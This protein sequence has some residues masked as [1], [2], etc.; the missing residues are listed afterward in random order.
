MARER[1]VQSGKP[2]ASARRKTGNAQLLAHCSVVITRPAG[3]GTALARQVR[4]LG[5]VALLLPGLSVRAAPDRRQAS[6]DWR[7]AQRDDVLIFT[8]PA[9][10]RHAFALAQPDAVRALV[11]ATG[12]GTARAL[13]RHGLDAQAP[14]RQDSEGVLALPSLQ[15][16]Q[17]RRVAL[18]TAPGGRGLLP[19][20]LA[21]RGAAVREVHVYQRTA[22]RLDRRHADAVRQLPADACV[23]LS[24]AEAVRYLRGQLPAAAWER[25]CRAIAIVSS[26]R[27]GEAARAA[28]FHTIYTAASATSADLLAAACEVCSRRCHEAAGTDC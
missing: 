12:Q 16:L 4:A 28:G 25:L 1:R 18:V 2:A 7:D 22:S 24:S 8:S 5:G 21:Q 20:R 27:I 19:S 11:I 13:R 26:E 9:A 15:E 23:L 10:V 3:T 14:S 6:A 17:G